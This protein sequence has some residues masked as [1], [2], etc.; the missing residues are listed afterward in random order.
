MLRKAWVMALIVLGTT[1]CTSLPDIEL[2]ERKAA[3][4]DVEAARQQL[5][6]LAQF[7]LVDAQIELG[8]LYAEDD[9]PESRQQAL[10]WYGLAAE[11]GSDRAK[12]RLGKLHAR[13]GHT[14]QQRKRGEQFLKAALAGGDDSALIPLINLYLD[15]P[16]E[17]PDKDPRELIQRARAQGDPAGDFALARYYLIR[18]QIESKASEIE[19]LCVP[20]AEA[21]PDCFVILGRLYLEQGRQEPFKALVQRARAAWESGSIEDRALYLFARSLSEEESPD[22]Q[23]AVT[24]E[25]Y[26]MLEASYVPAMTAQAQLIMDNTYLADADEVIRLLTQGRAHG[27][28]KASLSLARVYERGRIVPTDARKAIQ[29]AEEAREKYPSADYLLGRIYRR[30]YLGEPEPEKARDYLLS[31]A[32]RGFAKADYTLARLYWDGKGVEVNRQYA[33]AFALLALNGGVERARDLLKEMLP[34]LPRYMEL[35]AKS[36]FEQERAARRQLMA[37]EQGRQE[38]SNQQGG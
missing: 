5:Q 19:A 2:A 20:I 25:L 17:F 14:P 11:Q 38:S 31:A 1:G 3:E 22:R 18:G 35:E 23:V 29:F 4:G 12:G 33:W 28:L 37:A 7:G 9:A 6:E 34:G 27:D 8:D 13:G 26:Q 16:Q 15:Y 24:H 10:K 21:E 30:G 36:L 32:R